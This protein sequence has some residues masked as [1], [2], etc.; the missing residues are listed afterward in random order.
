MKRDIRFLVTSFCNYGCYFCHNEGMVRKN[1]KDNLTVEDY[2]WL[3]ENYRDLTNWNGVTLSGGEPLMYQNIDT[4]VKEL[5]EKGAQITIVTNGSLLSENEHL[6]MLKYVKRIN[7]SIHTMEENMYELI[8]RRKN[9][10]RTVMNNLRLIRSLYSDLE[11]RLNVT[12]CKA[13]GWSI[14][15]L[16]MLIEFAQTIKATIKCTELFPNTDIE[17]CISI[18]EL[19]KQLE[20]LRYA[21]VPTEDRTQAFENENEERV[22]LTQCTCAKAV[23]MPIPINYCRE[24]HDLYVNPNATIPLCRIGNEKIDIW[25]E[26]EERNSVILKKK[27]EIAMRRVSKEQCNRYLKQ[28]Y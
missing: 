2:V 3:Y 7:V 9:V 10:F 25:E 11:I 12:P 18:E 26:I 28:I 5:Y 17:N 20:T 16:K 27:M 8:T 13:N 15:Q 1:Y 21:E 23:N 6:T 22:F 4:L 14:G 24:T 19:K